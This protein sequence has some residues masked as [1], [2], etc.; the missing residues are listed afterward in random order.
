MA[1]FK[2]NQNIIG[3]NYPPVIIVELGINHSG[4]IDK[5]INLVDIAKKNGA[6]IIKHQTHIPEEEMSESAKKIIPG[7]S[8]ESIFNIIKK[9]CLS[10]EKEKKLANYIR[11]KKMTFITTPFSFAAVDRLKELK[12]PAIK[13]GS[14]EC[15]NYPLIKKIAS[16]R[17]PVIMSTGMNDYPNIQKAVNILRKNKI[18]FALLQ[19]TNVYP[20]PFNY[21]NINCVSELKRKF[22]DSVVGISDHST[23]IYPALSTIPLGSR[24][25]EK[26]FTLDKKSKGPDMSA[27]LDP[28]DLREIIKGANEIFLSMGVKKG[29]YSIEKPTIKFAF[30]SAVAMKDIEV[31]EKIN[32]KNCTFK[33]PGDG[34][35][36]ARDYKKLFGKISKVKIKANQQIKKKFL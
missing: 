25:I 18:K 29:P 9:N 14:G 22:P 23:S 28:V 5:A 4:N 1:K 26:H 13:I 27:S 3:D 20:T 8:N 32:E 17:L 12:V 34:D 6:N 36:L 2:I 10:L 35:F 11:Q 16:L 15:N 7:N 31:G 30:A 24:I 19:C 33:R 21:I